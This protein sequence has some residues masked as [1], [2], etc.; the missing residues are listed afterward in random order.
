MRN[1]DDLQKLSKEVAQILQIPHMDIFTRNR[2][3]TDEEKTQFDQETLNNGL[4]SKVMMS[5]FKMCSHLFIRIIESLVFLNK[6]DLVKELYKAF[7]GNHTQ[8]VIDFNSTY[9]LSDEAG[10]F[11]KVCGRP[12]SYPGKTREQIIASAMTRRRNKLLRTLELFIAFN[13]AQRETLDNAFLGQP[14]NM[15]T[16]MPAVTSEGALACPP[17]LLPYFV[18]DIEPLSERTFVDLFQTRILR[19][20]KHGFGDSER[21]KKASNQTTTSTVE[22][23]QTDVSFDGNPHITKHNPLFF[24]VNAAILTHPPDMDVA[25]VIALLVQGLKKIKPSERNSET[26]K[27]PNDSSEVQLIS[28][29]MQLFVP[30][31]QNECLPVGVFHNA[32]YGYQF[33]TQGQKQQTQISDK[34]MRMVFFY[35]PVMMSQLRKMM[36]R[37]SI[38]TSSRAITLCQYDPTTN[39]ANN[40]GAK[41]KS[42]RVK[43]GKKL[44]LSKN[45]IINAMI[46]QV[47]KTADKPAFAYIDINGN[48]PT[49]ISTQLYFGT[50]QT[51]DGTYYLASSVDVNKMQ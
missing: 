17:R 19:V 30:L 31:S 25:Q 45:Y 11:K 35:G 51:N 36:S 46:S 15:A 1:T 5:S 21:L 39:K 50:M 38:Q 10:I 2:F 47:P 48:A 37:L 8:E 41:N 9:W 20:A 32:R 13:L 18:L 27:Y 7:V 34:A 23:I 24:G 4:N 49:K 12:I 33:W 28:E 16:F 29:P 3:S 6:T 40:R 42:S 26:D 44:S 14:L 43:N 22:G